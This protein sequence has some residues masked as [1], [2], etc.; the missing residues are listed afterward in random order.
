LAFVRQLSVLKSWDNRAARKSEVLL[1]VLVTTL[2]GSQHGGECLWFMG[3][4][5]A[6]DVVEKW[7]GVK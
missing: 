4:E 5:Q 3:D 7:F 1:K 2:L 6:A